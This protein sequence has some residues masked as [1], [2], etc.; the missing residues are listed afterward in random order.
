MT[1]HLRGATGFGRHSVE[2]SDPGDPWQARAACRSHSP[3]LFFTNGR[4]RPSQE[5]EKAA[6]VVCRGCPVRNECGEWAIETGQAYGVWGGM[7]ERQLHARIRAR[8]NKT[9]NRG[10]QKQPCGTWA[11]YKRHMRNCEPIDDACRRA[12]QERARAQ[13]FRKAPAR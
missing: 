9:E 13:K 5:Q 11:A 12:Q 4:G 1:A 2:A 8:K 10:A 7:T 3:E 6:Q